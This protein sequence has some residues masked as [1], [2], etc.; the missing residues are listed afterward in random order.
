MLHQTFILQYYI[1]LKPSMLVMINPY[2]ILCAIDDNLF[3]IL[4]VKDNLYLPQP[5]R[6]VHQICRKEI[7]RVAPNVREIFINQIFYCL[8][9]LSLDI[10]HLLWICNV[11]NSKL[12]LVH[13]FIPYLVKNQ[14]S[15]GAYL[16]YTYIVNQHKFILH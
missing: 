13:Q 3:K 7:L 5:E 6:L 2:W 16:R 1:C 10:I 9:E 15:V 12:N 4:V 11:C 8:L 14:F